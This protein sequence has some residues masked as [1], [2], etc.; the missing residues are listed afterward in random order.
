MRRTVLAII[1]PGEGA[2][3]DDLAAARRLGEL[4]ARE[5][6]V[7]LTGGRDAGVMHAAAAGARDAGGLAVGLLP[8]VDAAGASPAL[9]L[10]LPTGLGEARNNLVALGSDAVAC[11]GMSPGTAAELALALRAGRPLALVR[12]EPATLEFVRSLAAQGAQ[13]AMD[14][15]AAFAQLRAAL[16]RARVPGGGP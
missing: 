1:G 8:G 4:A 10:A 14:A 13:A 2:R 16:A 3:P 15:D 11:C 5:G 12:P 7:V 6:W 9:D